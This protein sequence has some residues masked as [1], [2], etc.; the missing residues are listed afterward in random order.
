MTH[1]LKMKKFKP[2][3]LNLKF[4]K[5]ENNDAYE[6][7]LALLTKLFEFNDEMKDFLFNSEIKLK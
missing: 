4:Q 6:G 7:S 3:L 2:Q 1:K 5:I